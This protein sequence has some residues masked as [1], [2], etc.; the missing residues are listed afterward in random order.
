M[1]TR[2]T[3]SKLKNGYLL[4]R[5]TQ[6]FSLSID[7]AIKLREIFDRDFEQDTNDEEVQYQA[8]M[9]RRAKAIGL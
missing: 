1:N 3:V 7:D 6:I 4:E 5:G 8:E 9:V 2:M